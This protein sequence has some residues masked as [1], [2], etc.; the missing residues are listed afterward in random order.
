[1]SE[2][3]VWKPSGSRVRYLRMRRIAPLEARVADVAEQIAGRVLRHRA[4]EM[5]AEAPVRERG[6]CLAVPL[7]GHPAHEHEA[8]SAS[9]ARR[10]TRRPPSA[11]DRAG[12][13]RARAPP[14]GFPVRARARRRGRGPRSRRRVSSWIQSR[15]ATPARAPIHAA[16]DSTGA[17]A[18][19]GH[20]DLLSA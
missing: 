1:M 13:P 10:A 19:R 7:D 15:V 14:I 16:G 3:S 17:V 5:E 18:V 9:R 4:A 20:V 2:P 12:S 8:A 11:S 6:V